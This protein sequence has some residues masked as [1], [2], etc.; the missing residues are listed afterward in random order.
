MF[1]AFFTWIYD[2]LT[3]KDHK[4]RY[5]T[6]D[7]KIRG[8]TL[9]RLGILAEDWDVSLEVLHELEDM[10]DARLKELDNQNL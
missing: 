1:Y 10:I 5:Y 8:K 3:G 7:G 6:P 9:S 4:L 2:K